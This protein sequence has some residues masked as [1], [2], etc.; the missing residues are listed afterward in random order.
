MVKISVK[1]VEKE[2][3]GTVHKSTMLLVTLTVV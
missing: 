1:E 2:R 3:T